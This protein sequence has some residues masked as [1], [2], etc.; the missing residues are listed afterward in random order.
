MQA[1]ELRVGDYIS[2]QHPVSQENYI[3]VVKEM[4]GLSIDAITIDLDDGRTIYISWSLA[5]QWRFQ[6]ING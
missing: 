2:T 6:L 1:K 5:N 3:G 4:F